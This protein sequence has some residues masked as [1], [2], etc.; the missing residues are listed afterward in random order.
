MASSINASTSGAGGVITTADSSG[1]LN[2]QSGGSNIATI[3]STGLALNAGNITLPSGAAPAFSAYR[4]GTQTGIADSTYTK[5][6]L[7]TEV[8]DT[9]SA[10]DSTTNYRFT[11]LVAGYYQFSACVVATGTNLAF[12]QAVLVKN[13]SAPGFTGSYIS[14]T[15]G[16]AGSSVSGLFYLNGSTD[17]VELYCYADVSTG[18]V[19]VYGGANP[20]AQ[21]FLTGALVRSA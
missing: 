3:S 10:F 4:T 1:V 2:I 13:G 16:E 15:S 20:Q 14:T 19:T 7:N 21:T 12:T 6:Q 18:T 9:A 5:I 8:F 17:Y 11:P